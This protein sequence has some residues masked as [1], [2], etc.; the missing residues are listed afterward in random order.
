MSTIIAKNDS[1]S[2]IFI[3]DLGI[4]IPAL[5]EINLTLL[6]EKEDITESEDLD[7]LVSSQ[8]LII[9][10]GIEDLSITNALKHINYQTEYEDEFDDTVYRGTTPP[11]STS[12]LWINPEDNYAYQYDTYRGHWLTTAKATYVFSKDGFADGV[13]L[14]VG[15][16]ANSDAGYYISKPATI[17]LLY[18]ISTG[19]DTTKSFTIENN[20]SVLSTFQYNGSLQYLNNLAHIDLDTAT[21]LQVKVSSDGD[22]VENTVLQMEIAWRYTG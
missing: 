5:D 16:V 12:I 14:R 21:I 22:K 8:S 9:N 18:C 2:E 3:D 10:D 7:S 15:D 20:H 1:T 19:G 13:Y 17:V 6:F 11:D 4:G